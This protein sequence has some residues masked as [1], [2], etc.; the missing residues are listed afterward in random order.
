MRL[1]IWLTVVVFTLVLPSTWGEQKTPTN[2]EKNTATNAQPQPQV[3]ISENHYEPAKQQRSPEEE[4][5]RW[6]P[7]WW[8]PFWSNWAF[9]VIGGLAAGAAVWTLFAVREQAKHTKD[10][11]RAALLNAQAVINAERAWIL[12]DIAN[13]HPETGNLFVEGIQNGKDYFTLFVN[14]ICRNEG[15]SLAWVTEKRIGMQCVDI[16]PPEPDMSETELIEV[17]PI[18]IP[19][20]QPSVIREQQVTA[21]GSKLP[22]K[23]TVIYGSVKYRDIFDKPRETIFGY[24]VTPT[25]IERLSG[26]PAYNRTT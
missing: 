13:P 21:E 19:P 26:Y 22:G 23:M 7:P 3:S 20:T 16:L 25:R 14:L 15:R 1:Y 18:P 10:A 17:E 2:K 11:A 5:H 12:V 24:R 9:V 8:S 6:P 4:T